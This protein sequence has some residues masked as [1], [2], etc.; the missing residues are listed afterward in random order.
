MKNIVP[1]YLLIWWV[2]PALIRL[3][4]PLRRCAVKK[5]GDPGSG[6]R[7]S[8]VDQYIPLDARNHGY[9]VLDIQQDGRPFV[10]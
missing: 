2:N 3:S 1:D 5:R 7:L 4:Q 8:A 9:T 6:E 10:I